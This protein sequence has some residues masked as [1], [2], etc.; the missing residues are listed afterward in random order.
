MNGVQFNRS[1]TNTNIKGVNTF[2]LTYNNVAN[3]RAVLKN[4]IPNKLQLLYKVH[5][6]T[7]QSYVVCSLNHKTQFLS[8]LRFVS[9]FQ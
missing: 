4:K 2:F 8:E 1:V 9:P 6:S 5:A 7:L 3:L